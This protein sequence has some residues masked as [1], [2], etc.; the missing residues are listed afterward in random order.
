MSQENDS[1]GEQI[2]ELYYN[3]DTCGKKTDKIVNEQFLST[4]HL[5]NVLDRAVVVI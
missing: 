3:S 4:N 1:R 2:G 5:K